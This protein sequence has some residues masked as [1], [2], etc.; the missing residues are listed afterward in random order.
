VKVH[1]VLVQA[2]IKR[3]PWIHVAE[4]LGVSARTVRRLRGRYERH[5]LMASPITV[6]RRRRRAPVLRR[7]RY[8]HAV[9]DASVALVNLVKEK[10]RR[11][12]LDGAPLMTTVLSKNKPALQEQTCPGVQRAEGQDRRGRAGDDAP[13]RGSGPRVA[14]PHARM[15][16][17]TTLPRRR[18][19]TSA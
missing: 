1:E 12:D 16:C 11:H 18:W 9:L 2:L 15:R 19:S 7:A 6:G 3:R 8:R 5:G 10:S 17:S 4:L 13:V 14:Q